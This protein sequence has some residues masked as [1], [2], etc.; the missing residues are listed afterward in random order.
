MKA[1]IISTG[2]IVEVGYIAGWRDDRSVYNAS[3][4]DIEIIDDNVDKAIDW[5]QRRYEIAK[6]VLTACVDPFHY[7]DKDVSRAIQCADELIKQLKSK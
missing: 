7:I 5:E 4:S 2:E 6:D 3:S 1:R